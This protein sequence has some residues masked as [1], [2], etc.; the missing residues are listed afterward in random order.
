MRFVF[1]LLL[2]MAG[3][4]TAGEWRAAHFQDNPLVGKILDVDTG[5]FITREVLFERLAGARYI[6]LGE[7]HDNPDHHALQAAVLRALIDAGRTPAVG[8]EMLTSTQ[9][10]AMLAFLIVRPTDAAGL[11]EAVGWDKSGWP[12]WEIYQPVAE[13]ALGGAL[14]LFPASPTR[15][16]ASRI[17]QSEEE[18]SALGLTEPR[19]ADQAAALAEEIRVSHCGY[20]PEEHIPAMAASQR[21]RDAFMAGRMARRVGDGAVLIAG[22]GHARNDRGAPYYLRAV[23]DQTSI[24]SVG[25]IEVT[26]E[27]VEAEAYA[28]FFDGAAL[29]FDYVWF[30]PRVDPR[31][32]CT[33]FEEQLKDMRNSRHGGGQGDGQGDK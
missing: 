30:T 27:A 1:L 33:R 10:P 21:L 6:T 7:T 3:S 4:A 23:H 32:A 17:S 15:K 13:A 12:P 16:E 20:A 29:P 2:F 18:A 11:G 5:R 24:A 8:F 22:A 25:L 31:D 26:E 9:A 19:P 28:A 14:K